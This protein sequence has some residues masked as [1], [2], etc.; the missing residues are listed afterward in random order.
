MITIDETG[1]YELV[2]TKH[3]IKLLKLHGKTYAWITAPGIGELLVYSSV[4]HTEHEMLS[5]GS[6][7]LYSVVDEPHLSDQL[8]LEL[9][10]GSDKWQGYLLPTGFP[11]KHDTR[12]LII[13][14]HEVI[15][16]NPQFHVQEHTQPQKEP[17]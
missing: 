15:A 2:E 12:R 1:T 13:P 8:H 5:E 14:T 6:Y 17:T 16:H 4:P 10:F 11:T 3:V 9:E 7:R